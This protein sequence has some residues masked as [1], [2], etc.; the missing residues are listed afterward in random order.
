MN[1]YD[2]NKLLEKYLDGQ[3]SESEKQ[4]VLQWYQQTTV[5]AKD[6]L[7][8]DEKEGI[9]QAIWEKIKGSSLLDSEKRK[10]YVRS[11]LAIAA[12][13]ILVLGIGLFFTNKKSPPKDVSMAKLSVDKSLKE[14]RNNTNKSKEVS[15]EDGSTV[16]LQPKSYLTLPEHFNN[17]NRV[18]YLMGEALF[19]VKR[20]PTKPFLVHAGNLITEVLGTSFIIKTNSD[21]KLTEVRVLS[22]RVS[23]YEDTN[24]NETN[25]KGAIL[26]TNQNVKYNSESKQLVPSIVE[27]PIV[28]KLDNETDFIFEDTRL[29]KVLEVLKRSYGLDFFVGNDNL[30]YCVFTADLN[31]L[32][33]FS[34]LELICRAI[35]ARYEIRGTNIFINGEGCR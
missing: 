29:P 26:T 23:V 11:Y 12:S 17:Q 14:I 20:S 5:S 3:C 9:K 13:I 24:Q 33:L 8:S 35:N 30:N 16:V 7:L 28:V 21:S 25:R 22:G 1:Q 15:L 2:F 34:Q 10:V 27:A 31:G 32:P 6:I 18:V 19:K 4:T